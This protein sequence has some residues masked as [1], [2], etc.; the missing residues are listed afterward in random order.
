MCLN[1]FLNRNLHILI[2]LTASEVLR[3]WFY[4][5]AVF[6]FVQSGKS[7]INY[8][9]NLNGSWVLLIFINPLEIISLWLLKTTLILFL[10]NVITWN[11]QIYCKVLWL[12]KSIDSANL[13]YTSIQTDKV[14]LVLQVKLI[15]RYCQPNLFRRITNAIAMTNGSWVFTCIVPR[16]RT[17][18][19]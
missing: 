14:E 9:F 10:S 12:W 16:T 18:F 7:F 4:V 8:N 5:V 13:L 2:I 15:T 1:L 11:K 3:K 19:S 17:S 6:L